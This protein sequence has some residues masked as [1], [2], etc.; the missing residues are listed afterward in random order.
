MRLVSGPCRRCFDWEMECSCCRESPVATHVAT[1][2][3]G[4][5]DA[6]TDCVFRKR[7][8]VYLLANVN[9]VEQLEN[10]NWTIMCFCW[11]NKKA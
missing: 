6:D 2:E 9:G 3:Y 8:K 5:V 10:K 7:H 1:T 4:I 11:N